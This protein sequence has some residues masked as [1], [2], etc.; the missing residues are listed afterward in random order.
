LA[1]LTVHKLRGPA[2]LHLDLY[3]TC[4]YGLISMNHIKSAKSDT[5]ISRGDE[6]SSVAELWTVVGAL[7]DVVTSRGCTSVSAASLS[8]STSPAASR[9]ALRSMATSTGAAEAALRRFTSSSTGTSSSA[10]DTTNGSNT[11]LQGF[12]VCRFLSRFYRSQLE[13]LLPPH[14]IACSCRATVA[15]HRLGIRG[16]WDASDRRTNR[17]TYRSKQGVANFSAGCHV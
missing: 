11:Y 8:L 4:T 17:G 7:A 2:G 10:S 15:A 13:V 16:R 9:Q 14:C 6:R 12:L 3:T 5:C 1:I